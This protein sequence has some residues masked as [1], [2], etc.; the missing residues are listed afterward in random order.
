MTATVRLR[1]EGI[2]EFRVLS[3]YWASRADR[4]F[5]VGEVYQMVEQHDR[6]ANSHR[7]YFAAL[8]TGWDNLPDTM[9][10]EF[11]TAEHLR[12]KL[13][14]RAGYAD[15]RSIVCA[16]KSEAQRVAAF[17]KPM[18]E[19]AVVTV[20][21]AVVRVFTAQSQSVKAMGAKAFQESKQAVLDQL[22]DLLGVDRGS[23]ASARAA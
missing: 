3:N 15:E 1:Y 6:S 12:K 21:E 9:R 8:A 11:P 19:Y 13:L 2:G 23:T 10:D 22:D 18:D 17:V 5:V 20:R 16:S 7:H 14:V 4:D